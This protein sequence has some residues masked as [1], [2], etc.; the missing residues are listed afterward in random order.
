MYNVFLY[1]LVQIGAAPFN[2]GND[3]IDDLCPLLSVESFL[4]AHCFLIFFVLEGRIEDCE[5]DFN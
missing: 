3:K 2:Q 5:T 4:I 1:P